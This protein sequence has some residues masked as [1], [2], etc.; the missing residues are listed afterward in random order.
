[1]ICEQLCVCLIHIGS[2]KPSPAGP[3]LGPH[4]TRGLS[5][6]SSASGKETLHHGEVAL[7]RRRMKWRPTSE[8]DRQEVV[9]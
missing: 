2:L 8:F 4:A 6:Q 3:M 9:T 7:L 5:L 1:M